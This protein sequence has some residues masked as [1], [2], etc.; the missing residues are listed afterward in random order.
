MPALVTIR[1]RRGT[2]A[3]WNVA[4][5]ILASGEPGF[6]EDTGYFKIGNGTDNWTSLPYVTGAGGEL[7]VMQDGL[8][9]VQSRAIELL[10]G[11]VL[12]ELREIKQHLRGY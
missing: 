1:L 8:M 11:E 5:P 7:V 2:A 3:E 4:N 10:M 12:M 6:E 9:P